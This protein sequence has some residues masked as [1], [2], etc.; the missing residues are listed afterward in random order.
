[1]II[2]RS[3]ILI[4]FRSH[5]MRPHAGA[6]KDQTMKTICYDNATDAQRRYIEHMI[7]RD[8]RACQSALVSA[9]LESAQAHG[10]NDD[11]ACAFD[12]DQIENIYSDASCWTIKRCREYLDDYADGAN[13]YPSDRKDVRAWRDAVRDY[14]Q[15]AE[16]FEWWLI[17][18]SMAADALRELGQPIL[19]NDFGTWWGRTC[20]GQAVALDPTFWA[21]YQD[22]LQ[23]GYANNA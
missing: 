16:I 1:M 11:L 15:P 8:L 2:P 5:Q 13:C 9:L 20:T 19:D 4:G 17:G 23:K 22:A 14:A 3:P 6:G 12:S 18:D 10:G 7:A 21:I